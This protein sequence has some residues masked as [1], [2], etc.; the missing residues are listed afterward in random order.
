MKMRKN[1][2]WNVVLNR[3]FAIGIAVMWDFDLVAGTF[4]VITYGI[5]LLYWVIILVQVE[6]NYILELYA[7]MDHYI[8]CSSDR[9]SW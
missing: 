2:V 1:F 4:N 5:E 3:M 7:R 9:A 6:D 8:L